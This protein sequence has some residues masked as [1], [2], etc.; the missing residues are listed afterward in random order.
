MICHINCSNVKYNHGKD[1]KTVIRER[2][3]ILEHFSKELKVGL[4]YS[5]KTVVS[6]LKGMGGHGGKEPKGK[7]KESHGGNVAGNGIFLRVISGRDG[8]S[9]WI[10]FSE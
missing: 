8:K 5:I 4:F 1:L 7:E 6:H 10:K 9:F 3:N 2:K